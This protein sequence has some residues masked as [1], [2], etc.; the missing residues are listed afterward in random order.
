MKIEAWVH[1]RERSAKRKTLDVT[2]PV[3]RQH[4]GDHTTWYE[5]VD[6]GAD[7]KPR[8]VTLSET[9]AGIHDSG[10][11]VHAS[12]ELE[13]TEHYRF[14]GGEEDYLLGQGE[15]VLSEENWQHALTRFRDFQG[16]LLGPDVRL[17]E[18][19]HAQAK[20]HDSA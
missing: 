15:Y 18:A 1:P 19:G 12:Y 20:G 8:R 6:L 2:F 10:A 14:E 13:L 9:H 4:D 5:R 11:T 7:G 17:A 16:R 3:Y